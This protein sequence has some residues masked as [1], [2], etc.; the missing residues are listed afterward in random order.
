MGLW[1]RSKGDGSGFTAVLRPRTGRWEGR[2]SRVRRWHNK[3]AKGR[4]GGPALERKPRVWLDNHL[5]KIL[6]R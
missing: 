6:G 4:G 1:R 2:T 5:V 3:A